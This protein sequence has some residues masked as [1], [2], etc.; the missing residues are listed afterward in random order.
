MGSHG[1]CAALA[2]GERLVAPVRTPAPAHPASA[3]RLAAPAPAAVPAAL[4]AP[5]PVWPASTLCRSHWPSGPLVSA[6]RH[7]SPSVLEQWKRLPFCSPLWGRPQGLANTPCWP[8]VGNDV[9]SFQRLKKVQT[10]N[11]IYDMQIY[12]IPGSYMY[13]SDAK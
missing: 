13:N 2:S 5:L 7:P 1:V 4:C 10:K 11:N 3:R 12:E 8:G 6:A 9:Y